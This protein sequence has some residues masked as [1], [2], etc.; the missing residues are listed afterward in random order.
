MT[1]PTLPDA[2]R[3]DRV[4]A[5]VAYIH[6]QYSQLITRIADLISVMANA[7]DKR[8]QSEEAL[9]LKIGMLMTQHREDRE[10]LADVI[11]DAVRENYDNVVL[12]LNRQTEIETLLAEWRAIFDDIR[13]KL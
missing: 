7:P 1:N 12:C 4:E 11:R 9:V 10:F 3:L 13:G 8:R 2:D 5:E 6:D